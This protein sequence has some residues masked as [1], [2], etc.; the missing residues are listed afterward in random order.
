MLRIGEFARIGRVTVKAL[1]HYEAMGLLSPVEVDPSTGYRAY[2][3]KQLEALTRI[4]LLRDLG[5]SL[6]TIASLLR[7][8]TR[9]AS[10][11]ERRRSE[12]AEALAADR[13]RLRR[14]D[15]FRAALSRNP[16][17]PPV[18]V[19]SVPDS[20]ALAAREVVSGG[21]GQITELFERL[22]AEAARRGARAPQSPFLL[23]HDGTDE[24]KLDVEVCVPIKPESLGPSGTRIVPGCAS[25]G[26]IVYRGPYAQTPSLFEELARWV[27]ANGSGIGGPL[28]EVYLRFGAAQR[29]YVLPGHM[30]AR[31]P[32]DY[33]T[34]LLAPIA[35]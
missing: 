9:L 5:F 17:P 12:L 7:D 2:D 33:V 11:V 19:R 20:A 26:A 10:A 4:L 8:P 1:R 14:L 22:E 27:V 21:D 18:L 3:P 35:R 34:E 32:Q 28:R 31:D 25:A 15:A 30:L 23:F 16:A 13:R 6:K 24:T 29:G